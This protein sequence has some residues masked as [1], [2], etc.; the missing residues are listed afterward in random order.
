MA[1]KID[2]QYVA[3][4]D[5]VG[6]Q[7]PTAA[8]ATAV[9][10][11][12][13]RPAVPR[14][15]RT[16]PQHEQGADC[17]ACACC[18]KCSPKPPR[19][20]RGEHGEQTRVNVDYKTQGCFGPSPSLSQYDMQHI[21]Y[22]LFNCGVTDEEWAFWVGR[23]QEVNYTR[24][25]ACT[26]GC[27][28]DCL[29][30]VFLPCLCSAVCKKGADHIY[31]WNDALLR[32]QSDFNNQVLSRQGCMVKSKSHCHVTYNDKGEKQRH[33]DRWLAFALNLEQCQQLQ[34]E[35]H[36]T[37]DVERGCCNGVDETR[38]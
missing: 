14:E 22:Q 30:V 28:A 15:P 18:A 6:I 8:D 5:V 7:L 25:G 17:C 31:A 33:F 19:D 32:W 1:H 9:Y 34:Y 3:V 4:G 38:C 29:T 20:Q 2:P 27:W 10:V 36:I 23:L 16:A 13:A 12:V 11:P 26:L 37:G 24:R 35:P 21:P